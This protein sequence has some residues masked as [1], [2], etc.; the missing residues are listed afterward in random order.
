VEGKSTIY[1]LFYN[2]LLQSSVIFF[3]NSNFPKKFFSNSPNFQKHPRVPPLVF[4]KSPIGEH[5]GGQQSKWRIWRTKWPNG[6]HS[7]ERRT[8]DTCA[9]DVLYILVKESF[10]QHM[11]KARLEDTI[12]GLAIAAID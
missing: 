8:L 5:F 10:S 4:S 9:P 2:N 12:Y 1:N 11:N 7:P 3:K 6:E